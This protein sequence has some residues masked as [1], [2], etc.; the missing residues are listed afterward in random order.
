V[1][2]REWHPTQAVKE[3]RGGAVDLTPTVSHLPEVRRRALGYGPECEVPGPA[4]LRDEVREEFRRGPE[5]YEPPEAVR[6]APRQAVLGLRNGRQRCAKARPGLAKLGK[7][8][9]RV[10]IHSFHEF[11]REGEEM[12]ALDLAFPVL[13]TRLPCDHNYPLYAALSRLL[14][15]L[16][17]G[18]VPFGLLPITGRYLGRGEVQLDP[19]WSRLRLRVA[20]AD[21]PRVLPLAGKA[22]R[23]LGEHL[24]LGAPQASAPRPAPTLHAHIVTINKATEPAP[25][26]DAARR[27]LQQLGIHGRPE[28]PRMSGGKCRGQPQRTIL[29][30]KNNR[31]V[32]YA[33]LVHELSPEDSQRLLEAGLG[34]RR[35][36]G[37]GVFLP[38]SAGDPQ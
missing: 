26:L 27:Q 4:E 16:H 35:R 11:R 38:V 17:D 9:P 14:P 29:R 36:M 34:G 31:I 7:W 6:R 2:V 3:R 23:V 20:A 12:S 28:I 8:L 15:C 25:F 5:V 19:A 32:G 10:T 18:S 37:G 30:V 22:L 33:L 1:K 13:G 24:R 21:I